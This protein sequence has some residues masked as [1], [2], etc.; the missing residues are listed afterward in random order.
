[1]VAVPEEFRLEF[2]KDVINALREIAGVST[3]ARHPFFIEVDKVHAAFQPRE[4]IFSQ[5]RVDFVEQRLTLFKKNFW[6]PE[7]PRFAHCDLALSGDS[8]GLAIG[9]V[10]GFKPVSSDPKNPAYMPEIWIDGVL[11]IK[12]PKN[13][14]ILLS[15]VREVVIVLKRMG[16]NIVWMTFDQFQSSDSQQILRQ[17]GLIT[18]HQSMDEI[19]CRAYDFTKTAIYEGRVDI[20]KQ[21]HLQTEML[22]LEKDVKTGRIDH[23]PGGSKDLSDAIAGVCFGLTMRREMWGLYRIPTL[24]IPQSVY[25]TVDKLK[26]PEEQP[27][28]QDVAESA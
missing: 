23:P 5:T 10:R 7:V 15:K 6:N 28:Y 25:A 27:R 9:T 18:G 11:E 8:A 16:L 19:P 3:L 1:V 22:R 20:P 17:Q 4:S 21:L 12:P 13:C 2:E 14:E 24:M 26:K